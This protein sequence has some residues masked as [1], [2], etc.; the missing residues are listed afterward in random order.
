MALRL[1]A[2]KTVTQVTQVGKD[3]KGAWFS[4]GFTL[5]ISDGPIVNFGPVFLFCKPYVT[6]IVKHTNM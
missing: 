3:R 1:S 6:K 5:H 4:V 2:C